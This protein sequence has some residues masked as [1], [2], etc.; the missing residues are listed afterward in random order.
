MP[1][2]EL[3]VLS[4]PMIEVENDPHIPTVVS[5]VGGKPV[6][7]HE[8]LAQA[9]KQSLTVNEDFKIDLGDLE[10]GGSSR[11]RRFQTANGEQKSA[12]ELTADFLEVT[13]T[14]VKLWLA[15][16]GLDVAPSLLI[17]EP[18]KNPQKPEWLANYRSNLIRILQGKGFK[19][20]EIAFLPEPFAVFQYYRWGFRHPIL[21]DRRIHRALVLDFGG[22]TF[23]AC[24]VETTKE[25]DIK[26]K[27]KNSY[28]LGASSVPIG[29][30]EIN[31]QIAE[32]L[33]LQTHKRV[34]AKVKKGLDTYRRWRKDNEDIATSTDEYRNF[35]FNFHHLIHDVE[36]SKIAL[37]RNTSN[38]SLEEPPTQR[39]PFR[40]KKNLFEKGSGEETVFLSSAELLKIFVRQVWPRLRDT[41]SHTIVSASAQMENAP[42]TVVLLSGGSSGFGWLRELLKRDFSEKL[43]HAGIL[44]LPDFR[45]VVAKGLAIECA[46]RFYVD[47]GDFGAVTYNRLCLTVRADERGHETPKFIPR[48][49]E[50]LSPPEGVLL[51]SSS[52]LGGHIGQPLRWKFKLHHPPRKGLDY[53]F[54]RSSFDPQDIEN[55]QNIADHTVHTPKGAN[56][57]SQLQV[58]LTVSP[59]GTAYPKFIY[60]SGRDGAEIAA[61]GRPFYLDMTSAGEA[62]PAL[63]YLGLDFGTSNSALAYLSRE[64]VE[65]VEIRSS[66][67][68]WVSLNDLVNALPYPLA[69]PLKKVLAGAD[70]VNSAEGAKRVLDFLEACLSLLAYACYLE[71]CAATSAPSR[72]LK[73]FTQRSS[74]P[75]WGLLKQSLHTLGKKGRL[76]APAQRLFEPDVAVQIE[77]TLQVLAGVK[78]GKAEA[79]DADLMRAMNIVGNVSREVFQ[80]CAFGFFENVQKKRFGSTYQGR[81]RMAHGAAQPFSS[82]MHIESNDA[83]PD[84]QAALINIETLDV[85]VLEP[86]F[87]WNLTPDKVLEDEASLYVF[88][89]AEKD[90]SFSFKAASTSASLRVSS[91]SPY[92]EVAEILKIWREEDPRSNLVQL[93]SLREVGAQEEMQ[94]LDV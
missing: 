12:A 52:A 42:L 28:P 25:G 73:G 49:G 62:A 11:R 15:D 37:S 27:G 57:D 48:F 35:V 71:C 31:R 78:H 19:K 67:S 30:F 22:G 38:W 54:L 32:Y 47:Q 24:V 81:F 34:D 10:P 58:E 70:G 61:S 74:G 45:E 20:E 6:I 3:L 75:L 41:I 36:S 39:F 63:A 77:E 50:K 1:A 9:R 89:R 86:L 64:S 76:L 56:F 4:T 7:G 90:G 8:A 93:K 94:E 44:H 72:H 80:K 59:D 88:D 13:L 51:P 33:A 14:K 46:R 2:T 26:Q 66:D 23:D 16:N 43:G 82:W 17:A 5:Y 83:F 87:I 91:S 79:V 40:V 85:L 53:F 84:M 18:L 55:L 29:G 21:A 92:G 69:K 68:S 60:K 65:R